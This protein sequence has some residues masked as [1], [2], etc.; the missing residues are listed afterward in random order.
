MDTCIIT[1]DTIRVRFALAGITY[2][3]VYTREEDKILGTYTQSGQQ[4]EL[5]LERV[6]ELPIEVERP[7]T[8][9]RPF[10]YL[11]EEVTFRNDEAEITL[12]GTL[13]LPRDQ[14]GLPGV[15]LVAGSGANDRDETSMGHFLLLSDYLTRNGYAVLRFDKRGVGESEGD[16][17]AASTFDFADDARAALKYL[18][19]RDETDPLKTGM[20][21]HSEG[22]LIAPIIA[23]E[24]PDEVPYMVMLGGD[25]DHWYEP[26]PDPV[27][28]NGKDHGCFR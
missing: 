17:R 20:I 22:A 4:F 16:Y 5:N 1:N 11:E 8:P 13:T 24:H 14:K 28:I 3:G 6:D 18:R 21:G 9:V 10:P 26:S 15:V 25:R 2:E 7:Q 23:A 12:A 19:D 27:S